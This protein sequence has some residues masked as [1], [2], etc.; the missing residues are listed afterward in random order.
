MKG[1]DGLQATKLK[2]IQLLDAV[3]IHLTSAVLKLDLC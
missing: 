2:C 1:S 3:K